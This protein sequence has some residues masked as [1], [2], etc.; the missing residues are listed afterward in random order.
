MAN[1]LSDLAHRATPLPISKRAVLAQRLWESLETP[2][3]DDADDQATAV[4]D[5]KRRDA[6]LDADPSSGR[7]HGDV[8]KAA[9]DA[10]R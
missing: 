2:V 9:R 3:V 8:I 4:A 7:S 1:D 5:A 10:I 6:E